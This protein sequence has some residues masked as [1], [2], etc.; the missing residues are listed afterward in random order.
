MTEYQY[1]LTLWTNVY[2]FAYN[3]TNC[4]DDSVI[5]DDTKFDAWYKSEVD[6]LERD[7]NVNQM[8]EVKGNEMFIPADEE[9]AKEVYKLNDPMARQELKNKLD[10]IN[11]QN[12]EIPEAELPDVKREIQ[13]QA[14]RMASQS[15][16]D[17][18]KNG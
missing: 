14:N 15:T 12:R 5:G 7:K 8:G 10:F 16:Q 9:G 6:R 1:M 18:S 4:P 2:N 3:S 11:K 17:R 13:M